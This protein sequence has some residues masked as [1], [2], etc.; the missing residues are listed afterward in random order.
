[1]IHFGECGTIMK[2]MEKAF[3]MQRV[4]IYIVGQTKAKQLLQEVRGLKFFSGREYFMIV[5]AW[6]GME[7]YSSDDLLAWKRQ[8]SRILEEPGKGKDDQ[9]IGGHCDVVV[10]D[11]K[12]YV[13]YFTHP[14]RKKDNPAK[15]GSFDDKRSVIQVAELKYLKGE[16]TC[17]RNEIVSIKLT[18]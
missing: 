13:Y 18:R 2:K 15:K 8:P 7:V 5:D 9:A 17:D 4:R 3:G 10:N 11:G 1:M 16:V 6:K 14:G 12:A